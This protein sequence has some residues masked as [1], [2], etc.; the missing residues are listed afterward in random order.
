MPRQPSPRR[1]KAAVLASKAQH[2]ACPG[3]ITKRSWSRESDRSTPSCATPTSTAWRAPRSECFSAAKSPTP[4]PTPTRARHR[5]AH[6]HPEPGGPTHRPRHPRAQPGSRAL[7][8]RRA[9][10]RV[11]PHRRRAVGAGRPRGR[12]ARRDRAHHPTPRR[13]S[14][15]FDL[16]KCPFPRATTL[17]FIDATDTTGKGERY[18]RTQLLLL[19]QGRA[20]R[21]S[22]TATR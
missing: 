1:V 10:A 6:R 15:R 12:R 17:A 20:W 16:R 19:G 14:A 3:M 8:V 2:G 13:R 11:R 7:R 18:D 21:C 9:A 22:W 5:H 4:T